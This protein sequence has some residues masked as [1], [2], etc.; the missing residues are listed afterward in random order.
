MKHFFSSNLVSLRQR[1]HFAAR[2]NDNGDGTF[3]VRGVYKSKGGNIGRGGKI[4]TKAP[5]IV[6]SRE[7]LGRKN[8]VPAESQLPTSF[9]GSALQDRFEEQEAQKTEMQ[10]AVGKWGN[11]WAYIQPFL[12][13][14]TE[15]PESHTVKQLLA[16]PRRRDLVMSPHSSAKFRELDSRDIA[17][18]LIQVTGEEALDICSRCKERKGP[19]QGCVVMAH[20]AP[21]E[22]KARYPCCGNCVYQGKKFRCSLMDS[23]ISR[24]RLQSAGNA[25]AG[26]ATRE[27]TDAAGPSYLGATEQSAEAPGGPA[28]R[29]APV[30][31]ASSSSL[32]STGILQ[33]PKELLEMEDWEVA[34]GRIRGTSGPDAE[35][36]FLPWA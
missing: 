8:K 1:V 17:A 5:P 34:P 9:G 33:A 4:L 32:I 36:K 11:L 12:H 16:L 14:T 21:S 28:K 18:L 20:S 31:Q 7:P 29:S 19:F 10:A 25:G 24:D 22:V 13:D 15:V 23:I 3:S 6:V 27:H 2:L 35:S 26:R 30:V